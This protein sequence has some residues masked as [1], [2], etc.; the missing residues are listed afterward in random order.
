MN[1]KE[2]TDEMAPT[3]GSHQKAAI[4]IDSILTHIFQSLKNREEV[5][6]PGLGTF[7]IVERKARVGINPQSGK[8]IK[9]RAKR[10]AKFLPSKSLKEAVNT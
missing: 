10:S 9:I 7:R 1:K 8:K 2:L 6:L 4:V 3:V 5:R